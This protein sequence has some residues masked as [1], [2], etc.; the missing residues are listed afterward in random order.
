M[1]LVDFIVT[2]I[3]DSALLERI[4]RELE[5]FL[6]IYRYPKVALAFVSPYIPI[7]KKLDLITK[8]A[9]KLSFSK[10]TI[11]IL[12]VLARMH[13]LSSLD[14]LIK[15]LRSKRYSML[16]IR[17]VEVV[18][19]SKD[20]SNLEKEIASLLEKKLGRC[21]IS[22]RYDPNII[23]GFV[24]KV[25]SYLFDASFRNEFEKMKVAMR[26]VLEVTL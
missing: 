26:R 14:K 8:I 17:M 16:G 4:E 2:K 21:D 10:N 7:R 24:I 23:G 3:K 20:F 18:L 11:S 12:R 25:G 13:A 9:S 19:P 22:F 15:E 5:T 1:K 6:T